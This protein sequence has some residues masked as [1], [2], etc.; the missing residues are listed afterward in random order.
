MTDYT[1]IDEVTYRPYMLLR[2]LTGKKSNKD[3]LKNT[4]LV[5]K[6]SQILANVFGF[7]GVFTTMNILGQSNGSIKD[8][9]ETFF[10]VGGNLLSYDG[11]E[12]AAKMKDFVFTIDPAQGLGLI[13]LLGAMASLKM[14]KSYFDRPENLIYD[15]MKYVKNAHLMLDMHHHRQSDYMKEY[16]KFNSELS[17]AAKARFKLKKPKFNRNDLATLNISFSSFIESLKFVEFRNELYQNMG[18]KL[19][20]KVQDFS[21]GTKDVDLMPSAYCYVEGIR[22]GTDDF[23]QSVNDILNTKMPALAEEVDTLLDDDWFQAEVYKKASGVIEPK[24][25]IDLTI[26]S[27]AGYEHEYFALPKSEEDSSLYN[28]ETRVNEL[29]VK[30]GKLGV[31]KAELNASLHMLSDDLFGHMSE[32][33]AMNFSNPAQAK[34]AELLSKKFVSDLESFSLRYSQNELVDTAK[35]REIS[36][37]IKV[38]MTMAKRNGVAPDFSEVFSSYSNQELTITSPKDLMQNVLLYGVKEKSLN[39]DASVT[40]F[41]AQ[42]AIEIFENDMIALD[43]AQSRI[44]EI[45]KGVSK[46]LA[47]NILNKVSTGPDRHEKLQSFQRSNDSK[48]NALERFRE[49][50]ASDSEFTFH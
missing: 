13:G 5:S 22:N 32:I 41:I 30:I 33:S 36:N 46:N 42:T 3:Y 43:V 6:T 14:M 16:V 25:I 35:F 9:Y 39:Y 27:L 17:L 1:R 45:K 26:S 44:D 12:K 37:A 11:A 23:S 2:E 18:F 50:A 48:L 34:A 7:A 10:S 15:E 38:S 19:D 8:L 40:D 31:K 4:R 49:R 29:K 21:L 47:V 28:L 20:G 24:A